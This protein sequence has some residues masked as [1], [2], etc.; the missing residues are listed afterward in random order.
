M[1]AF[2]NLHRFPVL[3]PLNSIHATEKSTT[4]LLATATLPAWLFLHGFC[5]IN[6]LR[7]QSNKKC[8]HFQI[9]L[10]LIISAQ[11]C[12]GAKWY[13]PK[14]LS[15][16]TVWFTQISKFY[17]DVLYATSKKTMLETKKSKYMLAYSNYFI[18]KQEWGTC[19]TRNCVTWH[20]PTFSLP[21]F[22]ICTTNMYL[23]GFS[24]TR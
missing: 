11:V 21:E 4:S 23:V 9:N 17:Q 22:V 10:Y 24:I 18:L 7:L 20:T 19:S 15:I 8:T 14:T 3:D 13:I 1:S 12:F 6:L 2:H 16:P 5:W